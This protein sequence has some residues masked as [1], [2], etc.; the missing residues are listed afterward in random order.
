MYGL[1]KSIDAAAFAWGRVF[2]K[3]GNK[4][5][6]E[7]SAE[8]YQVLIGNDIYYG[9]TRA[10]KF[11]GEASETHSPGP[12]NKFHVLPKGITNENVVGV[13]H[14]HYVGSDGVNV[15]F[16]EEDKGNWA[17][18]SHLTHYLINKDGD[19]RV[20]RPKGYNEDED[21]PT[22][23]LNFYRYRSVTYTEN[24]NGVRYTYDGEIPVPVHKHAVPGFAYTRSFPVY[25]I[26]PSSGAIYDL[27]K[28]Q[29]K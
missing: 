17:D 16:S 9:F 23:G 27:N 4:D 10:V 5:S 18:Y 6:E 3:I 15:N 11:S 2:A 12:Y 29:L 20:H 28:N 25:Y 22:I 13:I 1:Y 14:I 24:I 21:Q 26:D 19:L 8:I 7:Y